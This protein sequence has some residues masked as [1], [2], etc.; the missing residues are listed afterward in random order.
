VRPLPQPLARRAVASALAIGA[1]LTLAACDTGDGKQL[2]PVDPA[3]TSTTV[4]ATDGSASIGTGALSS[5]PLDGEALDAGT[6][7]GVSGE[8]SA[9][10]PE[11]FELFTPWIAGQP[12][13]ER[14]TCD[15][16]DISPPLS[17]K[18]PPADTVQLAF[19]MIDEST[20]VDGRP[21]VHWVLAGIDTS[22]ISLLE[23][24]V[25]PGAIQAT[26]SFGTIGW[27]GPC[28]P[29]G[30]PAHTYRVTMYALNQQV[31]L[32]DGTPAE[33]LLGFIEQVAIAT[34]DATVTFQR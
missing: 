22:E 27:S 18:S 14:Y 19:A 7:G 23:D 4:A 20:F 10:D 3:S 30:E 1:A 2:Q 15:G 31:E 24:T 11:A 33:E 29:E 32:A 25:P 34:A 17:W 26:N 16:D 21:F 6:A 9:A 28:P 8:A 13:D 12:I 5:I